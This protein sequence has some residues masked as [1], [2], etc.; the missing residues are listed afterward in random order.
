MRDL[1]LS[2]ERLLPYPSS[3]QRFRRASSMARSLLSL[4]PRLNDD[5]HQK[6]STKD[7]DSSAPAD[8]P[9]GLFRLVFLANDTLAPDVERTGGDES[10]GPCGR[11]A[12]TSPRAARHR[13]T[14][15]LPHPCPGTGRACHY[16]ARRSSVFTAWTESLPPVHY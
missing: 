14:Q 13:P 3:L 8:V 15:P 2:L 6:T 16:P 7:V 9:C 12:G 11:D 10:A 4:W 5:E 1:T